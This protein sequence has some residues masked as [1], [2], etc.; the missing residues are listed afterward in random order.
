[1]TISSVS[2]LNGSQEKSLNT[3]VG[4]C[5]SH[6]H[7]R[8]SSPLDADHFYLF[9]ENDG[10]LVSAIGVYLDDEIPECRGFTRPDCR[11]QGY[12]R[13]LLHMLVKDFKGSPLIF[14]A[15]PQSGDALRTLEAIGARLAY[16][17]YAMGLELK[18]E[19]PPFQS[20]SSLT[21]SF[22]RDPKEP[23]LVNVAASRKKN[24]GS[25]RLI[26]Q[27]H[28]ACLFSF[29]I[30]PALRGQGLGYA[31]LCRLIDELRSMD[32]HTLNLQVSG[33]N[34]PALN[35]YKKTGFRVWDTLSYYLYESGETFR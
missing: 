34:L 18:K 13:Q 23:D 17:E 16:Q 27:N 21:L 10:S 14:S 2:R 19:L 32:I 15:D 26:F 24:V 30:R 29:E 9:W 25:C 8:L 28:T 7:F 35:L 4:L 22:S 11:R 6:E 33:Q 20:L 3:L 12:F 1:M 31:F 5:R